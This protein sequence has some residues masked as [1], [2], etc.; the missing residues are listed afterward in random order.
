[1]RDR[2]EQDLR[3]PDLPD[4]R[5]NNVRLERYTAAMAQVAAARSVPFV[6]LFAP[7]KALFEGTRAPLTVDGVHLN[8]EGNRRLAEIIDR[9]LFGP[10]THTYSPAYISALQ[11]A[12]ADRNFTWFNRYRTT[13]SFAT[14]GDR[15]FLTFIRTNPRDVNPSRVAI[16]KE[17]VLPTNYEVLEREVEVLDTMTSNRDQRIFRTARSLESNPPRSRSTIRT[18][19]SSSTPGPTSLARVPMAP[20]SSSAARRQFRR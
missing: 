1:M 3:N 11:R 16:N 8:E 15:A 17:D 18:R 9:E 20:T 10:P 14:F 6:N 12:V 19:R 2:R 5:E 7:T 4:G 13:D